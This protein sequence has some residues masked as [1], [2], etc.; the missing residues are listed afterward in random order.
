MPV[1]TDT[2]YVAT[3]VYH[4]AR[5]E[6]RQCQ[7]LVAEVIRN[8]MDDKGKTAKQVVKEKGQ[9]SWNYVLRNK[10]IQTEYQRLQIKASK[11]DKER[12]AL[13]QS[14]S[15]ATTVLQ[16]AYDTKS[17]YQ[18]FHSIRGKG[19]DAQCGKL[20]FSVNYR[21]HNHHK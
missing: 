5:G 3:A 4:E 10:T 21:S 15:I 13:A 17:N 16:P 20:K 9:F 12:K 8:R 7:L 19:F 6:P 14:V 11:S 1:S 2:L 18:Y